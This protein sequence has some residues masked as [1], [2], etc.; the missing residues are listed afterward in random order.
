MTDFWKKLKRPLKMPLT[1]DL[2][3]DLTV[4]K[5]TLFHLLPEMSALELTVVAKLTSSM[6]LEN[7]TSSALRTASSFHMK[8]LTLVLLSAVVDS[9]LSFP[10]LVSH[11]LQLRP[12]PHL[13][14]STLKL[15][16][17]PLLLL[18]LLVSS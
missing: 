11:S 17:L 15:S 5:I 2:N 13:E 3:V 1:V 6:M 16:S 9:R 8:E 12:R 10:Q 7:A 18:S 4:S 14:T